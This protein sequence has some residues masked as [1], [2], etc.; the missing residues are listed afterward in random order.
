M[1][2]KVNLLFDEDDFDAKAFEDFFAVEARIAFVKED[3]GDA[4]E[5]DEASA[6]GAGEDG[7]VKG[8]SFERDSFVRCLGDETRFAVNRCRDIDLFASVE[9]GARVA[10]VDEVIIGGE[11]AVVRLEEGGS[12]FDAHRADLAPPVGAFL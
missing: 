6:V 4:G 9:D 1:V 3:G 12:I 7:D 5:G 10:V 11:V 2:L 8:G